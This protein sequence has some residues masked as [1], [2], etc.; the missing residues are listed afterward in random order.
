MFRVGIL[1]GHD[2]TR[3][4]LRLWLEGKYDIS[5]YSRAEELL[6]DLSKQNFHLLLVDLKVRTADGSEVLSSVK[7][8]PGPLRPVAIAMTASAFKADRER[9]I[10]NGF[11]DLLIKPIDALRLQTTIQKYLR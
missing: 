5:D 11:N 4:L 1:D 3:S 9:A 2:D 7:T 8:I 10:K 6:A